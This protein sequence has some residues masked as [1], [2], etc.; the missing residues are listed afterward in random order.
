MLSVPIQR[1]PAARKHR[2][3]A[4]FFDRSC[5]PD[6]EPSIPT[7]QF[8]HKEIEV[9]TDRMGSVSTWIIANDSQKAAEELACLG[10]DVMR[11]GRRPVSGDAPSCF[12][13]AAPYGM[14]IVNAS[15]V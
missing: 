10:G 14:R 7:D 3:T 2:S 13:P 12:G 9:L 1:Q 6:R 4:S 5:A 8:V 15:L 11:I